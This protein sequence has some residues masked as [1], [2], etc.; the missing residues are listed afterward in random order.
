MITMNDCSADT[1][2]LTGGVDT[3]PDLEESRMNH[4]RTSRK[5]VHYFPSPGFNLEVCTVLSSVTTVYGCLEVVLM[6]DYTMF[7][8]NR[9]EGTVAL[10]TRDIKSFKTISEY[11]PGEPYAA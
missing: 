8:C 2:D 3:T 4:N 1:I 9:R 11:D 5:D 7:V 6:G 10:K